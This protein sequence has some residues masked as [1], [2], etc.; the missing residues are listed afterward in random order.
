MT[1]NDLVLD[2]E[3]VADGL[4]TFGGSQLALDTTLVPCIAMV[5]RTG[6]ADTDGVVLQRARRRKV[7]RYPELVERGSRARL[8]V[9]AV[10]VGGRWSPESFVAQV[11]K[12]KVREQPFLLQKR[13]PRMCSGKG[14]CHVSLGLEVRARGE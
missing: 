13:F 2:L 9:L 12:S 1:T 6:A 3:V 8:V 14:C 10:E 4:P 5:R 11:A 7:R